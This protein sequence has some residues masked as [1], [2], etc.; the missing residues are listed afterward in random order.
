MADEITTLLVAETRS[1]TLDVQTEM[2]MFDA[3][4]DAPMPEDARMCRVQ[5]AVTAFTSWLLEEVS[6]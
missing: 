1:Q 2:K 6:V 4:L 3:V 5:G